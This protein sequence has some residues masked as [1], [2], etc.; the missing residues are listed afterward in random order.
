MRADQPGSLEIRWAEPGDRTAIAG[1]V[2]Q[3]KHHYGEEP[4]AIEAAVAGWN[5]GVFRF[6][7]RPGAVIQK[8]KSPCVSMRRTIRA[9]PDKTGRQMR[10][11][12]AKAPGAF[13]QAYCQVVKPIDRVFGEP[14]EIALIRNCETR[15][16]LV[17]AQI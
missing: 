9:V 15:P 1:L 3:T 8:Q 11:R 12:P 7:A 16:S 2:E 14:P 4:E 10:K 6:Y 5:E 13:D 17:R